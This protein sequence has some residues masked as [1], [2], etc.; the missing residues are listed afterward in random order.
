MNSYLYNPPYY[1]PKFFGNHVEKKKNENQINICS[2]IQAQCPLQLFK[3]LSVNKH[4]NYNSN[5]N[6]NNFYQLKIHQNNIVPNPSK[7]IKIRNDLKSDYKKTLNNTNNYF[8]N[9]NNNLDNINKCFNKNN[10][11]SK[12]INVNYYPQ[13]NYNL[14]NTSMFNNKNNIYT[15]KNLVPTVKDSLSLLNSKQLRKQ[16]SNLYKIFIEKCKRVIIFDLDDTL[17]PTCW[18]RSIILYKNN[19]NYE[20]TIIELKKEIKLNK[21]YDIELT[22]CS[23]I[24][25]AMSLSHTVCI[26]TNARSDRW[27]NTVRCLFPQLSKLL[28]DM[29][30]PIIRT[31]QFNEPPS[32]NVMQYFRFWMN[33]KKKKFD[34]ILKRHQ[35]LYQEQL[36]TKIDFISLG[37]TEFEE[38]A[39]NELQMVNKHIIKKAFNIQVKSG[40]SAADFVGQLKLMQVALSIITKESFAC[41][42]LALSANV[43]I[44]MFS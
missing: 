16:N 9:A 20:E 7:N 14:L 34:E 1:K 21:E 32:S 19:Y 39:T 5:T 28:D 12:Y 41:N 13:T 10:N 26:V 2:H 22:A 18:L 42:Y 3:F 31:D 37:D 43:Q 25:L 27:V 24:K 6:S 40:L 11:N 35:Y 38:V 17:I 36:K 23:V 29:H 4:I 30:I 8:C 44:K 33:A 15:N